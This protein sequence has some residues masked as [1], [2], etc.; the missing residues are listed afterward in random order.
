MRCL[1]TGFSGEMRV[2]QKTVFLFVTTFVIEICLKC[3]NKEKIGT[4]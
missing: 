1:L 4:T 2:K 3:M